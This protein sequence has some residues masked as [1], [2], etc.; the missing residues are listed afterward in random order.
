MA[1]NVV[2]VQLLDEH[3][4]DNGHFKEKIELRKK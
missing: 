3:N 1:K 4:K 2:K